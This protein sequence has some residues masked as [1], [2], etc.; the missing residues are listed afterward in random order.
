MSNNL[1]ELY[2]KGVSA[3]FSISNGFASKEEAFSAAAENIKITMQNI[4][5][6]IILLK[7]QARKKYL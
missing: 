4:A 2:N 1:Q 5:R 7:P 3:I 6:T